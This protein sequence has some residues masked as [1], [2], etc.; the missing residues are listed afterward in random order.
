MKIGKFLLLGAS[1]IP[2]LSII[3]CNSKTN[4]KAL[5]EK[6][7][8]ENLNLKDISAEKT[9]VEKVN[10]D[11]NKQIKSKDSTLAYFSGFLKTENPLLTNAATISKVNKIIAARNTFNQASD[12]SVNELV[13]FISD[14]F[15]NDPYVADRLIGNNENKEVLV[16][17]FTGLDCF[18]YLD[19]V[20]ALLYATDYSSFLDALVS[21][22]YNNSEVT[23]ANRKHFFTDWE[24]GNPIVK[25]L[26]TEQVLGTE[27]ADKIITIDFVKNGK[28]NKENPAQR[29]SVLVGVEQ[30]NRTVKYLDVKAVSDE[31][32]AKYF[33][34]GDL[35]MLAAPAN[36]N[37]WL[38]VTH[39]GYLIFKEENGV[40]KA[41]YRNASSAKVNMKVVDTPLVE[42][43]TDRN[44][45]TKN[46]KPYDV[47]KV[48][49]ILLY[50][51]LE[52]N[53]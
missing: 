45:D 11:L 3:S 30:E 26:V 24:H 35:I 7:E 1:V 28:P 23:Y 5:I 34:D 20:N 15:L 10:E 19:Y 12:K 49:G 17:D 51:T 50:R 36:L 29:D 48:P 37:S 16:A 43:L 40:K 25:N 27:N 33:K 2:A 13:S 46:N 6:L 4:E 9:K 52:R 22:R 32:L 38:D 31:F 21:T 42:Y 44:F 8:T 47:P 53:N 18:T 39:C 41:Y 14:K